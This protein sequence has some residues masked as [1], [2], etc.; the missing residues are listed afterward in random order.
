MFC[1]YSHRFIDF[2]IDHQIL[3]PNNGAEMETGFW[4]VSMGVECAIWLWENEIGLINEFENEVV[5]KIFDSEEEW[6]VGLVLYITI[7]FRC[8]LGNLEFL[9]QWI[10]EGCDDLGRKRV[11]SL[12]V[13][14][15]DYI[16]WSSHWTLSFRLIFWTQ[17]WECPHVNNIVI[18]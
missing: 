1:P 15:F 11:G 9:G 4:V 14:L 10:L 12:V 17:L 6:R 5:K 3:S 2:P 16:Y 18:Q 7:N 8:Y 13:I